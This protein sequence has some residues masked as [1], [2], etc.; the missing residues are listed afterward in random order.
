M[1]NGNKNENDGK[2]AFETALDLAGFGL[3]N[4]NLTALTGFIIIAY[5]CIAFGTTI[6][7]PASAC[8]LGT[9]S[10]QQGLIAAG[11]LVGIILGGVFGGYL[12]DKF[13]R[14]RMLFVSLLSASVVNALASISVDWIMLLILQSIASFCAGGKYSLSITMLSESVPMA[15]RN[16]V[17]LLVTSISLLS[18]GIMAVIAIPIIPLSF[19]IYLSN[20]GIYWNSWRTLLLV[21]SAP[22]LVAAVW[23]LTIKESPKYIYAQ[24]KEQEAIDIIKSIHRLNKGRS[25]AE[26]QISGLIYDAQQSSG[27]SSTKEQIVPLFKMPLLKYTIIM[28]ILYVFQQVV[29][30]GVWLPSIANQFVQI[31][32]TGEG[33]DQ[34]LCSILRNSVDAPADPEAVPCSLNVISL[35]LVLLVGGLQSVANGLLSLIV[36]RVGRR[37]MAM[38]VAVVCGLAG[39]VTNLIPNAYASA[40]FFI[41]FMLGI[42]IV[43]LYTAMAV[44]LFPTNLRALAVALT[45]TGGRLGIFASVQILNLLLEVNCEAGFYLFCSIFAS[46]AIVAA[47]LPNDKNL[48]TTQTKKEDTS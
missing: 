7:I 34:S 44:A 11:P 47:F 32:Q 12:G 16:L 20:L 24:G 38:V 48:Q 29:A 46:S 19:S 35:L 27:P 8:E 40:A 33:T 9:T 30:F 39:I 14:R 23:M 4:Y 5:A 10:A 26:L 22:G 21:Y 31:V 37:N 17:V 6:I 18:Q 2:V 25:A 1:N 15:K 3:Y 28:T 42:L 36:D 13:G 45:M 41:L 43:G